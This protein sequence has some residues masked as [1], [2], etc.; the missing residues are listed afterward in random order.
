MPAE[1]PNI[2]LSRQHF[3]LM[4]D[5]Y[6]ELFVT[7]IYAYDVLHEMILTMLP[8]PQERALRVLELGVGTG[9][10]TARVLERFPQSTVVGYDLSSEMLARARAKLAS[11]GERVHL[12]EG[13]ISQT[14]YPG[15]FD[16]VISAIAV[17]H[18]PPRAKS[19]LFHRLFDTL[20]PGGVLILGDSFQAATPTLGDRYRALSTQALAEQGVTQT[21]VYATYRS[22]NNQPS[23]GE[24]TSVQ[25]YLLWMQQAGFTN[26]DC[27]WK[28][29]T[30]AV[31]YGERP[32]EG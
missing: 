32:I 30:R 13:D 8:F 25:K 6:D 10:L 16:A 4:A 5:Q 28:H 2:T 11:A 31:V 17:H 3:N 7:H 23:G 20:R 12:H 26:V 14:A 27:V 19:I 18:V 21:P 15:L 1:H 9:N 22:R 29:F 24:S